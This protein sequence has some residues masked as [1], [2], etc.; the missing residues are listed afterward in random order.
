M[1]FTLGTCTRSEWYHIPARFI[2]ASF[3]A[4]SCSKPHRTQEPQHSANGSGIVQNRLKKNYLVDGLGALVSDDFP[5]AIKERVNS[6][7]LALLLLSLLKLPF[8]GKRLLPP[9]ERHILARSVFTLSFSRRC[10]LPNCCSEPSRWH[11]PAR[12]RRLS[13]CAAVGE[14]L[15]LLQLSYYIYLP[16]RCVKPVGHKLPL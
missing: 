16:G 13:R 11:Q 14:S 5:V 8:A 4:I 2:L 12:W 1:R 10:T 7:R 9:T 15:A 3:A 6:Q